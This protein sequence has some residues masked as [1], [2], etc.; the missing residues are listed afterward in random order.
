MT[1]RNEEGWKKDFKEQWESATVVLGLNQEVDSP[2]NG[3][4]VGGG[5]GLR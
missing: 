5:V 2:G 3:V 4:R 1:Q